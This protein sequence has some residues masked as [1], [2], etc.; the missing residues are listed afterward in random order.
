MLLAMNRIFTIEYIKE[1]ESL[2]RFLNP[3]AQEYTK[4]DNF[5]CLIKMVGPERSPW[6]RLTKRIVSEGIPRQNDT[7]VWMPFNANNQAMS[8]F[9]EERT[10]V[11]ITIRSSSLSK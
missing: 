8:G 2:L 7:F 5:R 3:R 10:R 1:F 4:K 6:K 9:L 11:L